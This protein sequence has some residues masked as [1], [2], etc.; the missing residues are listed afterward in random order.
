MKNCASLET[1]LFGS[2]PSE[3]INSVYVITQIKPNRRV[4]AVSKSYEKLAAIQAELDEMN[5]Y[6]SDKQ[7][8]T[9]TITRCI[10][11]D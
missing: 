8:H 7:T 3:F 2:K 9:S 11:I 6:S 10:L 5:D 4:L 1:I